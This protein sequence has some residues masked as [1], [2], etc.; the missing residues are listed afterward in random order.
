MRYNE[1]CLNKISLRPTFLFEIHRC[2]IYT[3]LMDT[4]S[5]ISYIGTS[6]NVQFIK[7]SGLFRVRF[8][9]VSP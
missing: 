4:Y 9:Q 3:G 1:T 2:L 6:F 7:D 8:R 5:N